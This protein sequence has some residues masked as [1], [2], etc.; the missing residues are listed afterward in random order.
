LWE[1]KEVKGLGVQGEDQGIVSIRFAPQNQL[2]L[3]K[4]NIKL[5]LDKAQAPVG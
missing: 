1:Y 3:R 4:S 2:I 5:F